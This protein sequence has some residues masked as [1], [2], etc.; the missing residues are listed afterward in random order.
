MGPA[1]ND[2]QWIYGGDEAAVVESIANGRPGG[3]PAFGGQATPEQIQQVAAFV[4]S[5]SNQ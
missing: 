1:L 5:L 4:L 3:M 2:A